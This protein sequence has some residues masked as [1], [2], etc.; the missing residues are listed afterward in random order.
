MKYEFSFLKVSVRRH[1]NNKS[2]SLTPIMATA[3]FEEDDTTVV[4]LGYILYAEYKMF[5]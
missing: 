3:F 1:M 5:E 2:S 4:M